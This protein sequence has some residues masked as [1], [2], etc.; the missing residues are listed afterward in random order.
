MG[1]QILVS[2]PPPSQ[3]PHPTLSS[4]RIAS[5]NK[6]PTERKKLKA[7][8]RTKTPGRDRNPAHPAAPPQTPVRT[9]QAST[10]TTKH[11]PKKKQTNKQTN[12][13]IP[14]GDGG[15][16]TDHANPHHQLTFYGF[17]SN[18]NS[19]CA[20]GVKKTNTD[21]RTKKERNAVRGQKVTSMAVCTYGQK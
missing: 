6:F 13:K 11:D 15:W 18:L 10:T 12:K 19:N 8:E 16:T 3:T 5:Q 20:K 21:T 4:A 1:P 14:S 17:I 2:Y 9:A 7:T